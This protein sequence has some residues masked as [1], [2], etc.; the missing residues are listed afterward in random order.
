MPKDALVTPEIEC[1]RRLNNFVMEQVQAKEYK[2]AMEISDAAQWLVS[3]CEDDFLKGNHHNNRAAV[4]ACMGRSEEAFKEYETAHRHYERMDMEG[5]EASVLNNIGYLYVQ[6]G[7]PE[8]AHAYLESA[9]EIY[10]RL[11]D[12]A[13]LA[14]VYDSMASACRAEAARGC[15]VS[16]GGR[17]RSI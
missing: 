7:Q 1:L 11:G 14:E 4:L 3:G 16:G 15:P 8:N 2:L 5:H 12:N 10:T 6:I 13:R 9:R 17:R